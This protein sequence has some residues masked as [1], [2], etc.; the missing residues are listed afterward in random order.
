M[1]V[2]QPPTTLPQTP[3]KQR[4]SARGEQRQCSFHGASSP[5]LRRCQLGDRGSDAV[6]E[7]FAAGIERTDGGGD[8]TEGGDEVLEELTRGEGVDA[9][10]GL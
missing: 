8:C 6:S 10:E 7:S 4:P 5:F 3:R 1:Q 2:V 9:G